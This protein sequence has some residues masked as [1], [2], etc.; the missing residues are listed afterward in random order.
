MQIFHH[1]LLTLKE[2]KLL[3]LVTNKKTGYE[4]RSGGGDRTRTGV[5][6]H[7]PKA[8]YMLIPALLVGK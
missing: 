7:S 8:F 4:I 1:N 3:E 2:K 5:Q 6:T